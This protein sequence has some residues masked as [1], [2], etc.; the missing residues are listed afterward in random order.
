VS[1][2][3]FLKKKINN[4]FS[5]SKILENQNEIKKILGR[6]EFNSRLEKKLKR[7]ND[8]EFKIFSQFGE[9]GLINYLINNLN[10]TSKKFVE[11]GVENYEEANTRFLLENN[12]WTG[13]IFDSSK[14]N[15]DYIKN[16][17]YYWKYDLTAS[18]EFITKENI[19]SLIA[20]NNFNG[21]IGLLSIDVD[22]NDYWI[23]KSIEAINPNIVIIEFNARLG[24]DKSI[25]VPYK[26]GFNR[27]E[28]HYSNI[29]YGASLTALYKLG[30][31]KGYEL[32][33][34]NKNSNNAFFVK[35]N[36][37][38][39]VKNDLIKPKKPNECNHAPSFNESLDINGKLNKLNKVQE[40]EILE[41]LD[42]LEV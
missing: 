4:L 7:I 40:K 27:R 21:E 11:F 37:L 38:K 18:C 30:I 33:C 23:W 25:T 6:I 42:F 29:Y 24:I 34:T 8:Y 41:K 36:I 3:K 9:D 5:I 22:G 13:L 16:Q 31:S 10:I 39:D 15:L 2:K 14:E 28:E 19:N 32:V 17:N 26:E 20:K 1:I 35:S 12:G